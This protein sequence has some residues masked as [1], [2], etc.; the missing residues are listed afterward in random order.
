MAQ[1]SVLEV[2]L[3]IYK[4]VLNSKTSKIEI[5]KFLKKVGITASSNVTKPQ[6]SSPWQMCLIFLQREYSPCMQ[7]PGMLAGVC[8]RTLSSRS[9][10]S[11]CLYQSSCPTTMLRETCGSSLGLLVM[12]PTCTWTMTWTCPPGKHKYQDLKL[13]TSNPHQS[14]LPP[15]LV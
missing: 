6:S 3:Q 9:C 13:G 15:V 11:L 4:A 12:A 14:V 8:A 10:H 7:S 1:N 5:Q 2:R